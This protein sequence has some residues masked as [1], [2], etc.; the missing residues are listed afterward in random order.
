[1]SKQQLSKFD[2]L[3]KQYYGMTNELGQLSYDIV[4]SIVKKEGGKIVFEYDEGDDEL[5]EIFDEYFS[6][7]PYTDENEISIWFG[8]TS[9][10]SLY[11]DGVLCYELSDGRRC[12]FQYM[13]PHFSVPICQ[14]LLEW[15]EVINDR[16]EDWPIRLT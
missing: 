16:K 6:A 4:K 15:C 1:M 9:L 5:E 14:G 2:T 8:D 13:P 10:E 12:C 3:S 7:V 11:I